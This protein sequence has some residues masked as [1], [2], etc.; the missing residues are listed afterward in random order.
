MR[1][2]NLQI[3][4]LVI[5]HALLLVGAS[6]LVA[7]M[8]APMPAGNVNYLLNGQMPPGAVGSARLLSRAPVQNYYQPVR[9][10]GPK[11]A[12]FEIAEGDVFQPNDQDSLHAGLLIGAVYRLRVTSIPGNPGAEIYPTIEVIDRTYPP[13]GQATRFPIQINLEQIDMQDA[14][15]GRMVTRVVYLED[16]QS[17][18]PLAETPD[19]ARSFNVMLHQDPLQV[20]DQMGRPVAIIRIGSMT[21]PSEPS[22]MPQFFF[23]S[24]PWVAHFPVAAE[25]PNKIDEHAILRTPHIPRDDLG[26]QPLPYRR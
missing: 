23:G 17:A 2:L 14:L 8:T 19:T 22:L 20:A 3:R 25:G 21:P 18:L 1:Y 13:E 16:P 9:I 15:K 6:E 12:R 11:G 26:S 5:A 24:P 10:N 4:M 7:Q